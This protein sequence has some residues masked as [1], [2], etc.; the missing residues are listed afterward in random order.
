M[1]KINLEIY[2]EYIQSNKARNYE[3]IKTTYKVYESNMRNFL[4]YLYEFENDALLL[5]DDMLKNCV[6]ILERY[7]TNCR[8]KGNNNQT[9]NNK[10]VAISSFYIWC[11]KRDLIPYHPFQ[12]KLDR[13]KKGVFDKR[14]ESYFLNVE[15]IVKAKVLMAHN[16]YKLV[17]RI[18][19]ELFLDSGAR[20]SAIQNIRVGQID[21]TKGLV[22]DVKEKGGKIVDLMFFDG[23]AKLLKEYI[24]E[25]NSKFGDY[26]FASA[27]SKQK[28]ITQS[29]IRAKIRNIGRLIGYDELYPHTLRKTSI[30]MMYNLGGIELASEYANHNDSKTTKDHY[31]KTRSVEENR[32]SVARLRRKSGL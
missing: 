19:W 23:T 4:S 14:R 7:I 1:N 25:T 28:T 30:N 20:V 16:K 6:K 17:D 32:D 31:I 29:T 26:L 21:F 18:L 13:L 27:K 22:K 12:N 2:E 10:L 15:E 3:T 11:V 24:E 9:I 5:S 8:E